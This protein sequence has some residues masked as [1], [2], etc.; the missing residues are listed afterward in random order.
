MTRRRQTTSAGAVRGGRARAASRGQPNDAVVS[1]RTRCRGHRRRAISR[2][3]RDRSCHRVAQVHSGG[4]PGQHRPARIPL[5]RRPSSKASPGQGILRG[6][7]PA[8]MTTGGLPFGQ[9]ATPNGAD[10]RSDDSARSTPT[11]LGAR[12][13]LYVVDLTIGHRSWPAI[14]LAPAGLLT[15]CFCKKMAQWTGSVF[16]S[17]P[18]ASWNDRASW[19]TDPA[20]RRVARARAAAGDRQPSHFQVAAA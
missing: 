9:D 11:P 14:L 12:N 13:A 19:V 6:G 17:S 18:A 15:A 5:R 20:W 3:R 8:P 10:S 16:P 7:G 2:P 1:T 4:I